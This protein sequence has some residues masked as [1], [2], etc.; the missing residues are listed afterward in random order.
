MKHVKPEYRSAW[1]VNF[2]S[3]NLI[4]VAQANVGERETNGPNRS[5]WIDELCN[6]LGVKLGSSYCASAVAFWLHEVGCKALADNPASSQSWKA[7]ADDNGRLRSDPND[8]LKCTGALG[9]W[10]DPNDSAHG[11]I[12]VITERLTTTDGDVAAVKTIEANTSSGGSANGDGVYDRRRNTQQ[13]PT[14]WFIDLTGL[15]GCNYWPKTP[16]TP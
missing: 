2:M 11:H 12:F 16:V 1:R 5:P 6:R 15:P 3:D 10:T 4:E 7:W 8:L 13:V 9:G 14:L